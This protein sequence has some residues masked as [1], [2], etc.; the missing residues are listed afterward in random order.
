MPSQ[1]LAAGAGHRETKLC[2]VPERIT[3]A[4]SVGRRIFW[5]NMKLSEKQIEDQILD[6]CAA[7]RIL[8]FKFKSMGTFDPKRCIFRKTHKR[9]RKGVSDIIACHKGRFIAIEVKSENGE[10]RPEQ[11]TFCD[12][13]RQ[14]KGI[15]ICVRSVEEVESFFSKYF[16]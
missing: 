5:S 12:D 2:A 1:K 13:V 6:W 16:A 9:Y 8:A 7:K 4:E 11:V 14:A 10:L 3:V 15:F